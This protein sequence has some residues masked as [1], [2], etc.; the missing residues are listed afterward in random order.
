M[1]HP[2]SQQ[3]HEAGDFGLPSQLQE[4][5]DALVALCYKDCAH[6][7]DPL[8]A[9]NAVTRQ[10]QHLIQ[11]LVADVQRVAS[12]NGDIRA[13]P[14]PWYLLSKL[15]NHLNGHF[16]VRPRVMFAQDGEDAQATAQ[17]VRDIGAAVRA[18]VETLSKEDELEQNLSTFRILTMETDDDVETAARFVFLDLISQRVVAHR[19]V[20]QRWVVEVDGAAAERRSGDDTPSGSVAL[21][22]PIRPY[23]TPALHEDEDACCSSCLLPLF[24]FNPNGSVP[25]RHWRRLKCPTVYGVTEGNPTGHVHKPIVHEH[26]AQQ[27]F[28]FTR[29]NICPMCKHD[30]SDALLVDI[31]GALEHGVVSDAVE[32]RQPPERRTAALNALAHLPEHQPLGPAVA[33]ALVWSLVDCRQEVVLAAAGAISRFAAN[34]WSLLEPHVRE[35]LCVRLSSALRSAASDDAKVRISHAISNLALDDEGRRALVA[36][37]ACEAAAHALRS[38]GSDDAKAEISEAIVNLALNDEGRRALVA[39]GA[40]NAVAHALR[41]AASDYAKMWIS[42][43]IG[44]LARDD[45]GRCN[46]LF[47]TSLPTSSASRRPT[48]T[49]ELRP[50]HGIF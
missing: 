16:Q 2:L 9:V 26:C 12:A 14:V 27:W 24:E 32:W 42:R 17:A 50:C 48:A 8:M 7:S 21:P 36:A 22:T 31:E 19:P 30:F 49:F 28:I 35:L 15:V 44:F 37:G 23:A 5:L 38:A 1:S 33:H 13:S 46:I 18:L 43:A 6:E 45:E 29:K 10:L 47:R 39:A 41:S 20:D 40:Y 11:N 4:Q 34:L 3:A 25:L